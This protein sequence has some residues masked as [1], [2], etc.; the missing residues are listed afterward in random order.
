MGRRKTHPSH[1][2]SLAKKAT[3]LQNNDFFASLK[4]VHTMSLFMFLRKTIC[5][6]LAV[7]VFRKN[8]FQKEI[9]KINIK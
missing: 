3:T 2:T 4:A 1:S 6:F 9:T 5:E 8:P 7:T